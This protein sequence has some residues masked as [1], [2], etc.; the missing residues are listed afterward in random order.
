M[1][2]RTRRIFAAVISVVFALN[3]SGCATYQVHPEF[4]ERHKNI[5][6]IAFMPAQVEAYILTFQGDKKMLAKLI[7]IMKQTTRK[8]LKETLSDKG[9][10]IRKCDLSENTLSQNPDLRTA[11]FHVNELFEK[12]LQD[13]AKHKKSKFTYSLG[14]DVNTFANLADCDILV[15][16]K[17]DGIKK[18]AGEIAKDVV[19][20]AVLSAACLL[21]GAV[22]LPIPQTAATVV[23]I[24][25]VDGND[26]DILWY[27]NNVLTSNV[28]PENQ[29]QLAS[30]VKSLISP[31]P[32]SLYKKVNID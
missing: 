17:E 23:H 24:A 8:Q 10:G 7:P 14:S 18:S 27:N 29:K 5:R 15:F 6:S 9:Y 20:G 32:E 22:Y 30:L 21:V 4:K 19:K 3:I 25:I 13:I 26:G 12:Q 11:L 31:F 28:D 1:N 2:M 16:V